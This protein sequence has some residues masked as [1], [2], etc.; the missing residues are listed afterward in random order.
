[1]RQIKFVCCP[2]NVLLFG[3]CDEDAKLLQSHR[4]ILLFI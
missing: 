3:D 4:V 1:L 2:R